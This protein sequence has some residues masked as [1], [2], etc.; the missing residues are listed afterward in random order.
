MPTT[1]ANAQ[2]KIV[3][4]DGYTLNPGDLSWQPL[5]DIGDTI[6]FEHST[7]A[8]TLERAINADII[9]TNKAIIDADML[10]Q[11][12]QLRCICVL[13]TGFNNIDTEAASAKNIPV[14][15][16]AGYSTT[17]VAQHVFAL[18]F[19]LTNRVGAHNQDVQTG[20]WAKNRDFSYT[21]SPI[22]ELAGK[23][24]GI[25][26][27]GRIGQQVARIAQA[28]GMKVLAKHKHPERD[29]MPG[30]EFVD[31]ET[32]FAQSDVVTL[33]APL[34]EKNA[35]VV[36]YDLLASMKA[37]AY[38]INTA[39]GGLIN[40][41]DLKEALEKNVIAGAGLDVLSQE[42]PSKA[43]PLIGLS[44][45]VIT[46]HIAWASVEARQKLMDE[47]VKNV[48]AFLRGEPRNVV[49]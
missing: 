38:L 10:K 6:V 26:G 12:P 17:A 24:I 20:G 13:A 3:V 22:P 1:T 40:E 16:V 8:E 11:L 34:T 37:T 28:F 18:L 21:L 15:N 9:L 23:T 30:V 44:N 4:L 29:A 19:E 14:C 41:E 36:N 39:R 5:K 35:G 25:Y 48:E 42:P 31:M 27:F 45:C 43:H 47:T 33:H 46:P 7:R 32:L 49:N 2:P